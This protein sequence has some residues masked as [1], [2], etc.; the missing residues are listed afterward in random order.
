MTDPSVKHKQYDEFFD[1]WR[2]CRDAKEGQRAIRKGQ[3]MYLPALAGQEIA[4]YLKYLGRANFFNATA[5][6]IEAMSGMVFRKP[7]TV[8]LP[9]A[10]APWEDDITLSDETLTDFAENCVTEVLTVDRAGIFVDMPRAADNLTIAQADAQNIRPYLVLYQAESIIN[11]RMARVNNRYMLVDLWLSEWHENEQGE[12]AEQVRQLTLVDGQYAQVIWRKREGGDWFQYEV[13][14]PTRN[15]QAFAEIPFYGL[16]S[17]KARK[18]DVSTPPIEALVDVNIGHYQNSADL[19][20][21]A[22]IAGQPTPWVTGLQDKIG[23]NGQAVS[24][25]IYL[26]SSTFL[27][28]PDPN[29]KVGFLQCG[30]EGFATLEKLMESKVGQ[31][32][33]LGARMLAPEKKDAEAA[34]THEIKRGGESSVLSATCGVVE[35]QITKALQFAAA[36]VNKAGEISVELNRDFFPPNFTG[37]DLSAW[38][39]ARQAGEISKETLFGVLKYSEWLPDERTFGEEQDAIKEDGPT[40]GS[41]TD[42][43]AE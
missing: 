3:T 25:S 40:L 30:S 34:Q 13:I 39:A 18:M 8:E 29:T 42:T 20:N 27:S 33:A 22:H 43:P 37:A 14:V 1:V 17:R 7:M 6:T 38:V 28:F 10:M 4:D 41:L 15:A 35:R 12:Q 11:W 21:G 16:S 9:A 5:R 31:M 32:A 24:Q 26:G 2:K 19:E 36:W 23:E